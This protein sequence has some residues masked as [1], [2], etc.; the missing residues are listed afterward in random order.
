LYSN[1]IVVGLSPRKALYDAIMRCSVDRPAS[2]DLALNDTYNITAG[3]SRVKQ[4]A[5]VN[6]KKKQIS[7]DPGWCSSSQILMLTVDI[8]D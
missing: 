1:V 5:T 8:V 7:H 4:T 3:T 2:Y 6:L